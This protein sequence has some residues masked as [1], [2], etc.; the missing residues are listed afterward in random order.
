MVII[1]INYF[2]EEVE[3]TYYI[4]VNIIILLLISCVLVHANWSKARRS[5]MA[6]D[7]TLGFRKNCVRK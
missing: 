3:R 2:I 5:F 7:F 6:T 1:S 4:D